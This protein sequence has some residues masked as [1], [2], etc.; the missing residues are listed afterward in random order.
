VDA[1]GE[2]NR[3]KQRLTEHEVN[4]IKSLL[5]TSDDEEDQVILTVLGR[6]TL[7][8]AIVSRPRASFLAI[9]GVVHFRKTGQAFNS[10]KSFNDKRV[11]EGRPWLQNAERRLARS[12]LPRRAVAA[13]HRSYGTRGRTDEAVSTPF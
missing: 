12:D 7:T 1:V 8:D 10:Y 9:F 4:R 2:A 3:G 6:R 5:M 11:S 13:C